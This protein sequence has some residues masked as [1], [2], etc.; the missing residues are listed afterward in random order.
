MKSIPDMSPAELLDEIGWTLGEVGRRLHRS[1][2]TVKSWALRG[3]WPPEVVVWLQA[4]AAALRAVPA[5]R[6]RTAK[7]C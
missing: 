4:V 3:V 7:T 6:W 1:R 5:P 2:H